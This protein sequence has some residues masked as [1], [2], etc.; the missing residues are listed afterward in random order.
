M[1]GEEQ[2]RQR[3]SRW[4]VVPPRRQRGQDVAGGHMRLVVG[5]P[6]QLDG[7]GAVAHGEDLRIG[8]L[9]AG[10]DCDPLAGTGDA[11]GLQG[12]AV[13]LRGAPRAVDHQVDLEGAVGG[14]RDDEAHALWADRLDLD[15]GQQPDAFDGRG[16]HQQID[17]LCVETAPTAARRPPR[18]TICRSGGPRR[19]AKCANSKEMEPPP[20]KRTRPGRVFRSRKSSLV[21]MRRAPAMGSCMGPPPWPECRSAAGSHDRR[22]PGCAR[23]RTW[24]RPSK[25]RFRP[26][27]SP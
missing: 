19:V 9:H 14:R 23:P 5:H 10:V 24:R 2:R 4:V 18:I 8:G 25:S 6:R 15:P 13:E 3:P 22:P 1:A 16:L 26:C 21:A 12:E 27:R 7:G 20:T 11:G 17:H